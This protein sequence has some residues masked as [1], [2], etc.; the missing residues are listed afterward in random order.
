MKKYILH[1]VVANILAIIQFNNL[2][3]PWG[4]LPLDSLHPFSEAYEIANDY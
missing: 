1:A 2:G 4:L 3:N